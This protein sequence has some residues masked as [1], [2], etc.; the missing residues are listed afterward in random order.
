V[1]CGFGGNDAIFTV[2]AGDIFLGGEGNEFIDTNS[3][4]VY[5]G[6]GNDF[7]R[8]NKGTFDGGAGTDQVSLWEGGIL[9]NVEVHPPLLGGS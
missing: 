4:T 1:I 3:G 5:G 6:E 9:I 2:D 7:V 8:T